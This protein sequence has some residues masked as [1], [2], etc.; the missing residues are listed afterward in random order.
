VLLDVP[1]ALGRA[2]LDAGHA[3][4]ALELQQTAREQGS[5]ITSGDVVLVRTAWPVGRYEDPLAYAGAETGVPG[6]TVEAARWLSSLGVRATGSDTLAYEWLGP[7]AGHSLLPAHAHLL[8]ECGIHIL[9][10]LDLESLAAD[11]I[12]EFAFVAI[13]LKLVGATG[14]PIRPLAIAP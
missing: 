6:P 8:Y 10:V 12:H 11:S 13:P 9:E 5:E 7:G 2:Q 1:R 4:S 14:S 3:I